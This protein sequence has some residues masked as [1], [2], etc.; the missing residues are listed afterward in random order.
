MRVRHNQIQISLIE[1]LGS[2]AVRLSS[3]S[4]I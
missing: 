3:N 4:S 2:A 1:T